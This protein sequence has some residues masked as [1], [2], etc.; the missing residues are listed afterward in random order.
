VCIVLNTFKAIQL[1]SSHLFLACFCSV[2]EGILVALRK[3][4]GDFDIC[5]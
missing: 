5:F 2:L 3:E 4:N 1:T